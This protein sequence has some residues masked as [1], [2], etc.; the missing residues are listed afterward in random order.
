MVYYCVAFKRKSANIACSIGSELYQRLGETF[1]DTLDI[2]HTSISTSQLTFQTQVE[3]GLLLIL[4]MYTMNVRR[5]VFIEPIPSRR[6]LYPTACRAI[7]F[8][9]LSE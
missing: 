9:A 3:L 8:L 7:Y 2:C 1:E 4:F 5:I 6:E